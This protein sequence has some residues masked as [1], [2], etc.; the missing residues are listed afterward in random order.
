[1]N[2]LE[3][4]LRINSQLFYLIINIL[5]NNINII[6]EIK[7]TTGTVITQA[8]IIF[9]INSLFTYLSSGFLVFLSSHSLKNQTQKIQPN[10]ICVELTGNPS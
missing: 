6:H 4:K 1:M 10:A 3:K 9:Q 5:F 8:A 2:L 7:A